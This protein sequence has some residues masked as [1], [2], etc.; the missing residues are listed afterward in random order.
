MRARLSTTTGAASSLASGAV[1]REANDDDDV[2]RVLAGRNDDDYDDGKKKTSS[3]KSKSMDWLKNPWLLLFS[4]FLFGACLPILMNHKSVRVAH[5][6]VK[7]AYKAHNEAA[8]EYLKRYREMYLEEVKA[9]SN[10]GENVKLVESM[11]K[12]EEKKVEEALEKEEVGAVVAR[13]EEE[14]EIVFKTL[15]N[16][17]HVCFPLID[18]EFSDLVNEEEMN[19]SGTIVTRIECEWF[20]KLTKFSIMAS[21]MPSECIPDN[22]VITTVVNEHE[23]EVFTFA[24]QNIKSEKCF[25]DRFII[26]CLDDASATKCK[27]DGFTH[28]LQYV[29]TLGASD[30][31]QNDYWRIV[32]L[33]KKVVLA[34][35]YAKLTV[36][37]VDSDVL[38]L[39]VP[40]LDRIVELDPNSEMFHQWESFNYTA[41]F[42][43]PSFKEESEPTNVPHKG[44]N[45]GQILYLPTKNVRQGILTSLRKGKE[46]GTNK[47]RLSQELTMSGMDAAGV[48]RTG[49]SYKY[50]SYCSTRSSNRQHAHLEDWITF[51]AN[52]ARNPGLKLHAMGEVQDE[53]IK[54]KSGTS[55]PVE[56][57]EREEEEKATLTKNNEQG[58]EE[59]V[60]EL[61]KTFTVGVFAS[62]ANPQVC[63]TLKSA[64][65]NGLDVHLLGFNASGFKS[66]GQIDRAETYKDWYC[67]LPTNRLTAG[68][69]GFE[70]IL[71]EDASA[72]NFVRRWRL[73]NEDIEERGDFKNNSSSFDSFDYTFSA[74]DTVWPFG[75]EKLYQGQSDNAYKGEGYMDEGVMKHSTTRY[76][77]TGAWMGK[78]QSLCKLFTKMAEIKHETI[79][80]AKQ[81]PVS[82]FPS[83]RVDS[84]FSYF[85][86]CANERRILNWITLYSLTSFS[87]SF[88]TF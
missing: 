62:H 39:Q 74:T 50:N 72:K 41:L 29:E 8:K 23:W 71:Q 36:L 61:A 51:H 86:L 43:N 81:M 22:H 56:E 59:Q 19:E 58:E 30:F 64:I 67:N 38:F 87:L 63:V 5:A 80:T 34:F 53:W 20:A 48:K 69:A 26:L 12:E 76:V 46:W 57:E 24:T 9:K 65:M 25:L 83:C 7:G 82:T 52:C 2:E 17:K 3:S 27:N 11:I 40:N 16:G 21:Q 88:H 66:S 77:S 10:T 31:M 44:L 33:F 73:R 6:H 75:M 45:G 42:E 70:S 35:N 4:G 49:L 55:S 18:E 68:G 60:E 15:E 84:N 14:G 13:K 78:S 47:N 54:L 32:W 1:V 28:C 79:D 37:M 85:L